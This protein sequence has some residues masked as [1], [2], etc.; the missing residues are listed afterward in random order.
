METLGITLD[1]IF[2]ETIGHNQ[3]WIETYDKIYHL[4]RLQYLQHTCAQTLNYIQKKPGFVILVLHTNDA[5]VYVEYDGSL[6]WLPGGSIKRNEQMHDAIQRIAE[7]IH[8]EIK[9]SD[10]RPINLIDNTFCHK[11][12]A[13]TLHGIVFTARIRNESCAEDTL[14]WGTFPISADLI[15]SIHKY[16]NKDILQYFS[17]NIAPTIIPSIDD[18][19]DE[20]INTNEQMQ[21]RYKFHWMRGKPLL[22]L[23]GINRNHIIKDRIMDQ[24]G[25][26][27]TIIDISCGEDILVKQ[28]AHDTEKLV[29]G[30]DISRSQVGLVRHNL[31]NL[32]YTNHNATSLPFKHHAFDVAICKNTLHHMP[33]R[34]H[35]IKL[36]ESVKRISKKALFIE[37]ENPETT[38]GLPSKLHKHRYR[39]FLKDVWWAYLDQKQFTN[40]MEAVYHKTHKI[41]NG[42]FK[43]PQWNYFR[44]IITSL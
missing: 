37:I 20:E 22:R 38:W 25:D 15:E 39:G 2:H 31:P 5:K 9:L 6:R 21:L 18:R 12:Q 7:R 1:S 34:S 19:Q 26:A 32:L 33:H 14:Q 28:I 43:T 10:V 42:V 4:P 17:N 8:P 13:T 30:N 16:G 40:L 35:L 29:V 44:S 23:F 41:E 36:L 24:C 27:K 3:A 11:D